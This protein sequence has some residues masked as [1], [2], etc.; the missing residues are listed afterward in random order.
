MYADACDDVQAMWRG[1]ML[2][3]PTIL[4]AEDLGS[5]ENRLSAMRRARMTRA[6]AS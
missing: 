5:S 2:E 4:M 6:G 1:F 3:V